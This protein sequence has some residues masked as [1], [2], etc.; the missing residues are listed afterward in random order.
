MQF[1][2]LV[3]LEFELSRRY[4]TFAGRVICTFDVRVSAVALFR[5]LAVDSVEAVT[6]AK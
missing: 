3:E 2:F 4:S 6:S 1:T 5:W